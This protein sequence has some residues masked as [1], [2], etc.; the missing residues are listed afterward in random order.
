[1]VHEIKLV[2]LGTGVF[3]GFVLFSSAD[4]VA[5]AVGKSALTVQFVQGVFVTR[6]DP[7]VRAW[8]DV[9]CFALTCRAD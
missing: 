3:D 6:Y 4:H 9:M 7:T 1:M 8:C 2:V 5:G